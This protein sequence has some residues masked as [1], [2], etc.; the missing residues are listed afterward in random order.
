LAEERI[1]K[2]QAEKALSEKLEQ[3]DYEKARI[4]LLRAMIRIQVAEKHG[5]K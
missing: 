5:Q 3:K 4:D 2:E 1:A